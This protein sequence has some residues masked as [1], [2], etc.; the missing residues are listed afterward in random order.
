[1][2]IRYMV[3]VGRGLL[4]EPYVA[5]DDKTQG[6]MAALVIGGLVETFLFAAS[7]FG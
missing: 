2:S 4:I 1:M 6:T 3:N 5:K 7:I